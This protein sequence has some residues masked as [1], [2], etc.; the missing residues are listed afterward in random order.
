MGGM[1]RGWED[2]LTGSVG[3]YVEFLVVGC[4]MVSLEAQC[5]SVNGRLVVKLI[6]SWSL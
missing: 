2:R 5:C 4:L 1:A 3:I 6:G